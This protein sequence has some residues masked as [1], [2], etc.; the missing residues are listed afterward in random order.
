MKRKK[1]T[2]GQ[3]QQQRLVITLEQL[4]IAEVGRDFLSA[5]SRDRFSFRLSL[6]Y[7]LGELLIT[8]LIL[9]ER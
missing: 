6:F 9:V 7:V 5:P 1:F 4:M 2:L 8:N 3:V